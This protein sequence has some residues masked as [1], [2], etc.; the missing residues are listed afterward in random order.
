MEIQNSF[1]QNNKIDC[2]IK[3]ILYMFLLLNY[4]NANIYDNLLSIMIE[5]YPIF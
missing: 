2:I 4:L 1:L 5:K 3:N